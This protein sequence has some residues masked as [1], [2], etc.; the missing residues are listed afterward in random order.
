MRV[1]EALV[2]WWTQDS[3]ARTQYT[4]RP[5]NDGL[6]CIFGSK[7]PMYVAVRSV[8]VEE[9][10]LAVILDSDVG[11]ARTLRQAKN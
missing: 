11:D 4:G 10:R 5:P 3:L 7:E 2:V 1:F 6:K 9:Q 8:R